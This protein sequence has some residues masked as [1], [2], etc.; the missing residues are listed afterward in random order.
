M[1]T[2]T[3]GAMDTECSEKRLRL[4]EQ[5]ALKKAF[6]TLESAAGENE[7]ALAQLRRGAGTG[8]SEG[9]R[10][11]VERV[12]VSETKR[13][14]SK[15]IQLLAPRIGADPFAKVTKLMEGLIARLQEEQSIST[16]RKVFSAPT[17][18][19]RSWIMMKQY[20][21]EIEAQTTEIAE[22]SSQV[23]EVTQKPGEATALRKQENEENQATVEDAAQQSVE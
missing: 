1:G 5:E 19:S 8:R 23:A 6:A 12:V 16:T 7:A 17:R 13:L 11:R 22:L 21:A 9:I 18:A 15:G 20:T 10:H 14:H 2:N 4:N 3:L